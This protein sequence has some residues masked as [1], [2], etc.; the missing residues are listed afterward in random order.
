MDIHYRSAHVLAHTRLMGI[1]G[2]LH[3]FRNAAETIGQQPGKE[4]G[5]ARPD[6]VPH[7]SG[8]LAHAHDGM[9]IR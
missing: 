4:A 7:E 6:S 5:P 3:S 9:I 8:N 1:E 2:Q